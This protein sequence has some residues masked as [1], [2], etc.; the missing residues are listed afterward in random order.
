MRCKPSR[1]PAKDPKILGPFLFFVELALNCDVVHW[2]LALLA[3][4]MSGMRTWWPH[5]RAQHRFPKRASMISI[6]I[7]LEEDRVE[8]RRRLAELATA[9]LSSARARFEGLGIVDAEGKLVSNELPP[10]MLPDS[11]TTLE[12]G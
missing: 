10:D 9:R 7:D 6:S 2:R 5:L 1:A 3:A 11:D 4:S 8:W 12:T